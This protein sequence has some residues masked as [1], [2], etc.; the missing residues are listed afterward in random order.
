[1]AGKGLTADHLQLLV[2][3]S[4][5]SILYAILT[6]SSGKFKMFR[7]HWPISTSLHFAIYRRRLYT[8]ELPKT[9]HL[10]K[11]LLSLATNPVLCC[12]FHCTHFKA[13]AGGVLNP[14]RR[15]STCR[16]SLLG[17]RSVPWLSTL[18]VYSKH[19]AKLSKVAFWVP[20]LSWE[21]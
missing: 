3:S 20:H 14:G 9:F 13:T 7:A 15:K 2:L 16:L 17:V 21:S 11:E 4:G 5:N 1:M 18:S 6:L 12:Q 10:Y 19:Q 8:V